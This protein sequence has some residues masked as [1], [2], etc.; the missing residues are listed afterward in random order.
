MKQKRYFVLMLTKNFSHVFTT[1]SWK[2]AK[3][4]ADMKIWKYAKIHDREASGANP[5]W[6][7][8][9]YINDKRS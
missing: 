3:K 4:L 5:P 2:L 9:V 6:S 8:C 7:K 1:N